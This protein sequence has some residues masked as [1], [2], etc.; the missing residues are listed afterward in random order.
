MVELTSDTV[1]HTRTGRTENSLHR[2]PRERKHLQGAP[3]CDGV[4]RVVRIALSVVEMFLGYPAAG[5]LGPANRTSSPWGL[6]SQKLPV[7]V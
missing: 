4:S 1:K 2:L 7:K 3:S 6:L 5:S